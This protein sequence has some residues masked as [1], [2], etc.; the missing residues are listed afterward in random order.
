[1]GLATKFEFVECPR[2]GYDLRGN[3]AV[4]EE[5]G[6][7]PLEGKCSECGLDFEWR[8]V[9]WEAEHPWL[10][11]Y[12]WR[13]KPFSSFWQTL[14]RSVLPWKFWREVDLFW[15]VRIWPLLIM[16]LVTA[17]CGLV[18]G[19]GL[20]L[21]QQLGW[22][23]YYGTKRYLLRCFSEFKISVEESPVFYAALLWAV[24][25]PLMFGLLPDSLRRA[26]VRPLHIVRVGVYSTMLLIPILMVASQLATFYWE[27]IDLVGGL[28]NEVAHFLGGGA[29][30]CLREL[31]GI[32]GLS[33]DDGVGLAYALIPGLFF[34]P[35]WWFGCTRYLRI[36]APVRVMAAISI[37]TTL[38]VT[39]FS[40]SDLLIGMR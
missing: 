24:C 15:A 10:F 30:W 40:M 8:R 34:L 27:S 29:I 28:S 17:L 1:M 38:L 20:Q 32:R 7:C 14:W 26:K 6:V 25:I 37:I 3:V 36:E 16:G 2:C 19:A 13:R 4:W 9:F 11:E 33:R 5:R 22:L 31:F 21:W 35:Y 39:A 23:D 18:A 12:H